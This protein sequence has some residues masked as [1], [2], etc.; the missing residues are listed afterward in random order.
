VS[1][2][3]IFERV[4]QMGCSMHPDFIQNRIMI[5]G[6]RG[7]VKDELIKA[8]R[9]N[10]VAI[11]ARFREEGRRGWNNFERIDREIEVLIRK[12]RKG[13]ANIPNQQQPKHFAMPPA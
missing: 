10:K 6:P 8:V 3:K 11:M 13:A 5:S 12:N 9:D 7:R 4:K 2:D 1:P